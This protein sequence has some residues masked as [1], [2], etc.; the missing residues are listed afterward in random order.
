V[1][2]TYYTHG[3]G[4]TQGSALVALV[5]PSNNPAFVAVNG[6]SPTGVAGT[7][8]IAKWSFLTLIQS[9]LNGG[10]YT[11]ATASPTAKHVRQVPRLAITDPNEDTD[12][13]QKGSITVGWDTTWKRWDDR[14]YTADPKYAGWIENL[15]MVYIVLYSP[16]NGVP[17]TKHGNPTGWFY[18]SD[19]KPA[20][21]GVLDLT[22]NPIKVAIS[23]AKTSTSTV[24]STPSSTFPQGNYL[25]RVEGYREN[26][27]LHYSFHQYRA[28]FQR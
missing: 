24:W 12:L 5:D 16:S 25:I 27:P 13:K 7:T 26:F 23:T 28:F 14:A 17:D 4:E 9:Y 1:L 6:L 11:D 8:F 19:N 10:L 2:T 18:I 22:H 20:T 15:T 3:G 21:P